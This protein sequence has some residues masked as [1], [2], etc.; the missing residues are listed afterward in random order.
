MIKSIIKQILPQILKKKLKVQFL[1]LQMIRAYYYDFKRYFKFSSTSGYDTENKLISRIILG[2]HVIE[3]GLTMPKTRLGFGKEKLKSLCDN[4]ILY[5][6]K[7]GDSDIQLNHAVGVVLEYKYYH[8]NFNFILEKDI[9]DK[10]NNLTSY[11]N[12][13]ITHTVQISTTRDKYF[14][15]TKD[16]FQD[17]SNSRFSVRNYL[18]EDI[19][20]DKIKESLILSSNAPSACNRQ[21][22]RTYLITKSSEIEEILSAQGG[23]RG[24]GH[25]ANKLIIITSELSAFGSL[26]ERNQAFIDGGIYAMNILYSLHYHEIAACI[27]NCSFSDDKDR[28]MRKLCDINDSEVFIAMIAC[29]IPPDEFKIACSKRYDINK[30]NT[31]K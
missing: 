2:Y 25:L 20:I 4:C 16:S 22:W 17:F 18:S 14:K 12:N 1:K 11:S 13:T 7:Y 19:P 26:S 15:F 24:F 8:D 6:K 30:T 10:I 21:S 9:L 27:L 3:K 5:M 29:G 23:N 31:I 28:K